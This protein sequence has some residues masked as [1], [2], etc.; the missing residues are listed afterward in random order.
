MATSVCWDTEII[1][2]MQHRSKMSHLTDFVLSITRDLL[3]EDVSRIEGIEGFDCLGEEALLVI[4]IPSL[5]L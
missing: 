2:Q 3:I 4:H 1:T 5:K